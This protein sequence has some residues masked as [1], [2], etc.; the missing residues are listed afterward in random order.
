MD[1]NI[2]LL[3]GWGAE[4]RKLEPLKKELERLGWKVSLPKLAGFDNPP[5]KEVWGVREYSDYVYEQASNEFGKNKFF[6]FGH[7]FGG[8]V[9]IKLAADRSKNIKGVVLCAARGIFRSNVLK[10]L[11][12]TSLAKTGKLLLLF[13]G[14]ADSFRKL[15][16]KA[17]REHD[18]EKTQGIMKDIFKKVVSE[19]LKPYIRKIKIPSLIL[20][21]TQDRMTPIRGGRYIE[22]WARQAKLVTFKNEGHRLPYER[23]AGIADEIEKWYQEF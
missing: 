19:D 8:G 23:P 15:L 3:H 7:S 16:Y 10:R 4:T 21:G 5:P 22:K 18:Y 6:V 14:A 2:V 11:V 12:F 13:P 9:A 20:W 17:A 1:K